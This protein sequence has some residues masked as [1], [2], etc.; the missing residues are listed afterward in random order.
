MR[1]FFYD[2]KQA[3][4]Y[5]N[6]WW[7]SRHPDFPAF[8]VDC[9]NFVS[10]AVLAGGAPMK[11]YPDQLHGW[12]YEGESWSLSWAVA[13]SMY[14]FLKNPENHLHAK[15]LPAAKALYPGDVICYDFQGDGRWDHTTIVVDHDS[16]G[17]PLVNAHTDN[18]F[19]RSWVYTDSVAWTDRIRYAFFH[20]PD[21]S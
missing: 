12:W 1:G 6:R 4:A 11:G 3:V 9:T 7:N 14:W 5:A 10:Q 21:E 19:R 15:A 16:S 17:E 20:I 13:H 2:R 8:P 18:S